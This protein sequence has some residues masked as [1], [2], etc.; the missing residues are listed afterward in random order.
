MPR[1]PKAESDWKLI[2]EAQN[3]RLNEIEKLNE[4]LN[5]CNKMLEEEKT[6]LK[7]KHAYHYSLWSDI[8]GHMRCG[9]ALRLN[10]CPQTSSEAPG[11]VLSGIMMLGEG[12]RPTMKVIR[13]SIFRWI[14]DSS[15]P[16]LADQVFMNTGDGSNLCLREGCVCFMC[17]EDKICNRVNINNDAPC[18]PRDFP[19]R[20]FSTLVIRM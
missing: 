16:S 19:I 11:E 18:E 4:I 20:N 2:S 6:A 3:R 10:V 1:T 17:Y 15:N 14:G 8:M 13:D 5:E 9:F 7:K 12:M